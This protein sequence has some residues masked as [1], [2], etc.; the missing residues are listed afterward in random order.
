[1]LCLSDRAV[2]SDNADTLP[3]NETAKKRGRLQVSFVRTSVSRGPV[4]IAI[5]EGDI[6][7]GEY[8]VAFGG[9]AAMAFSGSN[10]ASALVIQDR[11]TRSP[12]PG[13]SPEPDAAR[14]PVGESRGQ[15]IVGIA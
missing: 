6:L 13:R 2:C 5:R 10:S 1:L 15:G 14:H 7:K 11:E 3:L 12:P 4:T 9:T 8:R